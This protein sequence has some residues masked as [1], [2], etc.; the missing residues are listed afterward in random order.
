MHAW[1]ST[2]LTHDNSHF[3][4]LRNWCVS[5]NCTGC[6]KKKFILKNQYVPNC[7]I[8]NRSLKNRQRFIEIFHF[9]KFLFYNTSGLWIKNPIYTK[10]FAVILKLPFLSESLIREGF[11]LPMHC[12]LAFCSKK[13]F[14]IVNKKVSHGFK[15][16]RVLINFTITISN[17]QKSK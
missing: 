15:G 3:G 13:E 12:C 2:S 17:S 5:S 16:V 1:P 10:L 7:L 6:P 4:K 8:W 11:K 9:F 14:N